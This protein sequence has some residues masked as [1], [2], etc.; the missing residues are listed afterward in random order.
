MIFPKVVV[1]ILRCYWAV[2]KRNTMWEREC[3]SRCVI[4]L[5]KPSYVL[6]IPGDEVKVIIKFS[7][8]MSCKTT[9]YFHL[10]WCCRASRSC[11]TRAFECSQCFDCQRSKHQQ[12]HQ[13]RKGRNL[14][15]VKQIKWYLITMKKLHFFVLW[16]FFIFDW[17]KK[18][19]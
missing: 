11:Q 5:E 13:G 18:S 16:S 19:M 12:Y 3:T 9:M 14:G 8:S 15:A 2:T 6:V 1:T 7:S 10:G 17:S 4:L